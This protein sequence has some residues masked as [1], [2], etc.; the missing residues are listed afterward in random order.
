MLP[1]NLIAG[2]HSRTE[3]GVTIAGEFSNGFNDCGLWVR[4][5]G[6]GAVYPGNC[7]YWADWENWSDETREGIRMYALAEMEALG[8]WFFWTW[9]VRRSSSS[10]LPLLTHR[11]IPESLPLSTRAR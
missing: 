7:E 4:G 11:I 3:F 5:I 9:K 1:D 6:G 2:T 8:D 10:L